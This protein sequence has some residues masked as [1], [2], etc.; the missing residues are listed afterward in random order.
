[1]M[2]LFLFAQEFFF[3]S[4]FIE[5][6]ELGSDNFGGMKAVKN[7]E[8]S[9]DVTFQAEIEVTSKGNG[10]LKVANLSQVKVYDAHHDTGLF[11][12]N[13][14]S[15]VFSDI[16]SDGFKDLVISGINDVYDDKGT[17]IGFHPILH[18]FMFDSGKNGFKPVFSNIDPTLKDI[19][20]TALYVKKTEFPMDEFELASAEKSILKKTFSL[21]RECYV[22]VS[23][24]ISVKNHCGTGLLNAPGIA[25]L[26]VFETASSGISAADQLMNICF[27]DINGDGILDM[28]VFGTKSNPAVGTDTKASRS[29][30]V[31]TFLYDQK[32][33][34]FVKTF[35]SVRSY[36]M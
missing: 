31:Y 17:L 20:N 24:E 28:I 15:V 36:P 33:K 7:V 6:T 21:G 34:G 19:N 32:R 5:N 13:L 3:N 23:I 30:C 14:L 16:N 2:P 11:R 8:I 12:D 35:E 26:K 18:I 27:C 29:M 9:K 10:L 22:P 1:M 4:D 25:P